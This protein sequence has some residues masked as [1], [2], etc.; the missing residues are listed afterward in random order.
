[1]PCIR[2]CF[3]SGPY[4]RSEKYGIL[5][6]CLNLILSVGNWQCLSGKEGTNH[7]FVVNHEKMYSGNV[8]LLVLLVLVMASVQ[9]QVQV[10]VHP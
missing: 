10:K 8:L 3:Y 2:P 9:V 1:M 7:Y 5:G 6:P 4:G